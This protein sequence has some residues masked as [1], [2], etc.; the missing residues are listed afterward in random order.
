MVPADIAARRSGMQLQAELTLDD[1]VQAGRVLYGPAFSADG[2]GWRATLKATYRRRAMETHPDR[3]RSIGRPERELAREFKAVA[4]AYRVLCIVG[5]A[6][7]PRR[8]ASPAPEWASP[9]P[10]RASARASA[11][12]SERRAQAAP[13]RPAPAARAAGPRVRVGVRPEDLPRRKLRFAE[14]LYYAGRIGWTELVE[15]IAWQRAQRP[16]LGRIA[17]DFGFLAPEDVPFLLDRR[18]A[19]AATGTPFGEWA[20]REGFLTPFQ[21][22]AVVGQQARLQRPIGQYFVERGLLDEDDIELVR[23]RILRHNA[24][25]LGRA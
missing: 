9:R 17:V 13:P 14:Y 5:P 20:L 21:L 16:P 24:G 22:L 2:G 12:T 19:A 6:P 11:R 10:P 23:R 18:R 8:K 7:L 1:V 15:A 4:D 3:A 25:F